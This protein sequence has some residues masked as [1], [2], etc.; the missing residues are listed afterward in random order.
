MRRLL[1]SLLLLLASCG[2]SDGDRVRLGVDPSW[3]PLQ[4]G[5]TQPYVNGFVEDLLL[6]ISHYSGLRFEKVPANWDALYEGLQQGLYDGVLTSL[7]PYNYN[8]A[9]YDFTPNFLSLG[10]IL[11]VPTREERL[12]LADFKGELIGIISQDPAVL[13]LEK[14]PSLVIR[15][16]PSIPA[17]LEALA[18]GEIQ[19]ALLNQLFAGQYVRDLFQGELKLVG[20][21]LTDEGLHLITLK[22][23]G[24][25]W[26]YEFE[27]SL[28]QM[29][30]K[31]KL[32]ALSKKWL[33][34]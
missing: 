5:A 20:A 22:G 27:R 31:K 1:S 19:G 21:P 28:E 6:E 25:S 9:L 24:G 23:K 4:F 32:N 8:L 7:P 34:G 15:T 13:L 14:E 12:H 17:L 29:K 3:S 26:V 11:V 10:P 16:F 18:R 30:K 2:P 33:L